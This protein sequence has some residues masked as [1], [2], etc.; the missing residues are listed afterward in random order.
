MMV[1]CCSDWLDI[2]GSRWEFNG[3]ISNP[4]KNVCFQLIPSLLTVHS[5][6]VGNIGKKLKQPGK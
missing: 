1:I 5:S 2:F 4:M 6:S 3:L